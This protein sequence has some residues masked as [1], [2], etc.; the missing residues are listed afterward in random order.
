M[1]KQNQNCCNL[2]KYHD[3]QEDEVKKKDTDETEIQIGMQM[4][5]KVDGKK[6]NQKQKT[7][8]QE[9]ETNKRDDNEAETQ[10]SKQLDGTQN[11]SSF[12]RVSDEQE[13]E[14][15]QSDDKTN[16]EDAHFV[17]EL[18]PAW[19]WYCP[20]TPA[21]RKQKCKQ[22]QLPTPNSNS[23]C[24]KKGA[25]GAPLKVDVIEGDGNCLFRA[26]SYE[27]TLSQDHHEFFR[28]SACGILQTDLYQSEFES[29]HLNNMNVS[30]YL[31]TTQM[32]ISGTWGTEV[33]VIAL[34]TLLK[35]TIAIYYHPPGAK[36]PL[37]HHY[38]PLCSDADTSICI[39]LHNTG[40]HFNHVKTVTSGVKLSFHAISMYY[41]CFFFF[42]VHYLS[43]TRS[44]LH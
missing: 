34:A 18:A 42:V 7:L 43:Y 13:S 40:N 41:I 6:M 14:C 16:E 33:E 24:R 32:E 2:R 9:N 8:G 44:A 5:R 12:K 35:T 22:F 20:T 17:R 21:W 1:L 38:S 11:D 28:M 25:L 4:G 26:I 15:T 29:R 19:N 37:W 23:E 30:D 3:R 31:T 36:V 39:Y 27:V 10:A